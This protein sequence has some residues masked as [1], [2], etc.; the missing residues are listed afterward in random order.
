MKLKTYNLFSAFILLAIFQ[1][2][3]T[4]QCTWSAASGNWSDPSKWSNCGGGIPLATSDVVI[5]GASNVTLDLTPTVNHFTLSGGNVTGTNNIV[6]NGNLTV[7]PFTQLGNTGDITVAGS[8]TQT[9]GTIGNNAGTAT[10]TVT[11]AG[12]TTFSG[13]G[14][15]Y[16]NAKTLNL[17]G[18]GL[19]NNT[20]LV[21]QYGATMNIAS[22]QTFTAFAD[23][24]AS[25]DGNGTCTINNYGNTVQTGA[26]VFVCV[27]PFN[28]SGSVQTTAGTSRFHSGGTHT[29]AY[30][31]SPGATLEFLGGINN[32]SACSLSGTGT[33]KNSGATLTLPNNST[34]ADVITTSGAT[35]FSGNNTIQNLTANAGTLYFQGT[36]AVQN[37]SIGSA[38][39][40]GNCDITDS[41]N[42]S[43]GNSGQ[44]GNTGNVTI[45]GTFTQT[46]G[47]IGNNAGTATGT[48]TIAGY[49][50][51]S[52]GG[53]R[54]LNTKT[55]NLNGGGTLN[56][57]GYTLQYGGTLNFASGQ[58]FSAIANSIAG[59]NSTNGFINNYGILDKQGSGTFYSEATFNNYG[60]IKGESNCTFYG[61]VSNSG[62]VSPGSSPGILYLNKNGTGIPLT[63]LDI[64]LEGP[65]PGTNG[66]DQ[67]INS[68][69]SL[70]I[71]NGI[72]N[73]TL[74][75]GY[76]PPVGTSFTIISATSLSGTFS[77]LN[78]P[79]SNDRWLIT[80]NANN[81]VL[82]LTQ[83][84]PVEL[85]DFQAQK[86]ADQ[87]ALNWVTASESNNASFVIERSIDDVNFKQI[88]LVNSIGNST[89]LTK[90][91]FLDKYPDAGASILYYRLKI[92]DFDGQSRYSSVRSVVSGRG[93]SLKINPTL[94][95]DGMINLNGEVNHAAI[96]TIGIYGI[97]GNLV[98]RFEYEAFDNNLQQFQLDCSDVPQGC[99]IVRIQND[100]GES[101]TQQCYIIR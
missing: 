28:N 78:L 92:I 19:L 20:G 12:Y 69:G 86:Q 7:S 90:Y 36:L 25:I 49:T 82:T 44:L 63:N 68:T 3:T 60:T 21:M 55:M 29:G 33:L 72:L 95:Y 46:G 31:I 99:Y 59:F 66:Y 93:F 47:T 71:N 24:A 50:T 56:N 14:N 67:V 101:S 18:G 39:I 42:F 62:L 10:G 77:T 53:N 17:N 54:Y 73:V 57:T 96:I 40:T 9:G 35:Y 91:S 70:T 27:P 83:S 84:L 52:G 94:I 81:V 23:Y 13:G 89:T 6:V 1:Q 100:R 45:A 26:A 15:R 41:G 87:I 58:T 88:G 51:F 75:N 4:A 43:I 76:E 37:M 65:N 32:I 8:L 79:V 5:T 38:L 22:G 80:Y 30:S 97:S 34:H 98:R 48:V 61:A 85:L 11:I 16:L 64:E 2:N 74:L